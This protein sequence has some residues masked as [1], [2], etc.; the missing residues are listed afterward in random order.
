MEDA[1][2]APRP[3]ALPTD[4]LDMLRGLAALAVL[5]WHW[6]NLFYADYHGIQEPGALV[7]AFYFVTGFGHQAVM[8]F[9]VL[10]GYFIGAS[11]MRAVDLGTWSWRAYLINRTS[12]LW[13][14]L[15]PALA[16]GAAWD[17]TGLALFGTD[18]TYGG[19]DPGLG[20]TVIGYAV[21]GRLGWGIAL[22][23]A[24]FVQVFVVPP[25]GSNGPLWSLAYEW[26]FYVLFPLCALALAKGTRPLAR[27][28]Y[29]L[30]AG[31]LAWAIGRLFVIYFLIWLLGALVS[32]SRPIPRL[33]AWRWYPPLALLVGGAAFAA[34][35]TASRAHLLYYGWRGDL[36]VGLATAL[37]L[38]AVVTGLRPSGW[39]RYQALATGL[40]GFAY[41]L[42]LVHTPILVFAS[43]WLRG[44]AR[45]APDAAHALPGL[46]VLAAV[47]AYAWAVARLTEAHTAPLRHWLT[48]HAPG[49][50]KAPA[51]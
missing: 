49:A 13:V 10:S 28:G 5:L 19:R 51:G 42:Y 38:Y 23:N 43:T 29:A 7:G 16:L 50:P 39:P 14:V 9:F 37:L 18:G 48:R 36:V 46:A 1:G 22:G 31:A 4:H 47:L 35:A 41:T 32:V 27:L 8:V 17:L 21:E 34:T 26:W 45:W 3:A 25:L 24:L 44:H 12:R 40:A 30:A 6:R 33:S 2:A 15:L 20:S 11:V